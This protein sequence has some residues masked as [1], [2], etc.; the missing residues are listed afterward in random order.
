MVEPRCHQE[1][2]IGGQRVVVGRREPREDQLGRPVVEDY[3][4]GDAHL[5]PPL[6]SFYFSLI[7]TVLFFSVLV[8]V[9]W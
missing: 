9:A 4:E 2:D 8:M 6:K 3:F 5:Q 7:V 1:R